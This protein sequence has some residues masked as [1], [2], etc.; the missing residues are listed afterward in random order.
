[1]KE[2]LHRFGALVVRL[3]LIEENMMVHAFRKG[4]VPGPFIE[5]LIRNHPKTFAEIK[6]RAVANITAEEE[7]SEKRTC[8]LPT[9]PRV[10]GRPQ[11]LSLHE[12]TT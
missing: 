3:N 12:A 1:M 6:R 4:I 5:S 10:V 2:F 8:V 9:R 7:L 11:T